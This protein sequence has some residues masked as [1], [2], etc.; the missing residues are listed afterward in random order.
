MEV[1]EL[2]FLNYFFLINSF[3]SEISR[4][5]NA[6]N[7]DRSLLINL[8]GLISKKLSKIYSICSKLFK[9]YSLNLSHSSIGEGIISTIFSS[10]PQESWPYFINYYL[11]PVIFFILCV[12]EI[13]SWQDVKKLSFALAAMM[14][15]VTILWLYYALYRAYEP[16][17]SIAELASLRGGGG[18]VLGSRYSARAGVYYE[19]LAPMIIPI[20]LALAFSSV[21]R[22]KRNIW[23]GIA[24]LMMMTT[25]YTFGRAGYILLAFC[26]L[27]WF[28]SSKR[29]LLVFLVLLVLLFNIHIF[30]AEV[31]SNL[32]MRFNPL[33]SWQT[34]QD[35]IRLKIWI[36]SIQMLRDHPWSGIGIRM[37]QNYAPDYGLISF[38]KNELGMRY[39]VV[40]SNSHGT[41]FQMISELGLLGLI[42]WCTMLWIPLKRLI[43]SF[44]SPQSLPS[45]E[46]HWL[47]AMKSIALVLIFLFF[48]GGFGNWG[49]EVMRICVFILWLA[50]MHLINNLPNYKPAENYI[51]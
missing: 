4:N 9:I 49:I 34:M 18:T 44:I 50:V 23:I 11:L 38:Y 40:W 42:A 12:N 31:I 2:F 20:V 37:F 26:L 14:A 19:F 3:S 39:L 27:P 35:E 22:F 7:S 24:L 47:T 41:L 43:K 29:G 25:L 21:R 13:N 48:L 36:G 30:K 32:F 5:I 45:E 16:A 8:F 28:L 51:H 15:V 6:I 46:K 10:N 33:L 1:L 17:T